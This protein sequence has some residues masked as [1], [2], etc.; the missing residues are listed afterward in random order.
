MHKISFNILMDSILIHLLCIEL[1]CICSQIYL[2]S[3]FS[4]YME[5]SQLHFSDYFVG[6]CHIFF[7]QERLLYGRKLVVTKRLERLSGRLGTLPFHSTFIL[8]RVFSTL[9]ANSHLRRRSRI[10]KQKMQIFGCPDELMFLYKPHKL[11]RCPFQ[12]RVSICF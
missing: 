9:C 6:L 3:S 8:Y 10:L 5:S 11:R 2:S 1:T 4:I 7:S 12:K